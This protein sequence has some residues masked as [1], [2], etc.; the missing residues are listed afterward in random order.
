M[1]IFA[2]GWSEGFDGPGR[3]FVVYLKGC[4]LRCRWC[5]SP[6]GI[7]RAPQMLFYPAHS[8]YAASA[9]PYGAVKESALNRALCLQCLDRSCIHVAKHPAFEL[10]GQEMSGADLVKRAVTARPL[11]GGDGGVTFTGGEPTLQAD[12][13]LDAIKR[14]KK[15]HIHTA[16][17]TNAGTAEF[18]R[19]LGQVDLLIVDLKCVSPGLHRE[20]TGADNGLILGNLLVAAANQPELLVRV[21]LVAGF[22]DGE[23]EMDRIAKFLGRMARPRKELRVQVLPFHHMGEPKYAALGVSYPMDGVPPPAES[24]I[25]ALESRLTAEGVAVEPV[26]RT[27][28]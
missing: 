18:P 24:R 16:V 21:P 6:E 15:R 22:N 23:Q 3:R 8:A 13:V 28:R 4:N 25:Q 19:F 14:L 5:A 1:M 9:C 12:E 2:T 27:R 26:W 17:E 11:F 20:W 10:A 7:D